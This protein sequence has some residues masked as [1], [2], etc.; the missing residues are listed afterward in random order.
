MLM[1]NFKSA[2]ELGISEEQKSALEKTLVLL[3]TGKLKHGPVGDY[4]DHTPRFSGHFNMQNWTATSSCGTVACIGGTAEL[5]GGLKHGELD[6]KACDGDHDKLFELFY[7]VELKVRWSTIIPSQ[8]AIALRSYLTTGNA[9]WDLALDV[10]P[11]SRST[12]EG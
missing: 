1:Q 3:E 7:P 6:L 10:L 11:A 12:V 8:A 2:V 5:V 4:N 9:R